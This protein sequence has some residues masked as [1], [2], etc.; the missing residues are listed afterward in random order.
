MSMSSTGMVQAIT[1]IVE[2]IALAKKAPAGPTQLAPTTS[3]TAGSWL[4]LASA[5]VRKI[6]LATSVSAAASRPRRK[7][8][9]SAGDTESR[10]LVRSS[11]GASL[12]GAIIGAAILDSDANLN[13]RSPTVKK[14]EQPPAEDLTGP[15]QSLEIA[16]TGI[17]LRLPHLVG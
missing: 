7:T 4:K 10:V 9:F 1:P 12:P 13:V 15:Q 8:R 5:R 17:R 14:P 16:A 11:R 6:A 2:T 3:G